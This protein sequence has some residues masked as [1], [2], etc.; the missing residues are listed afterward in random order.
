MDK[1]L[2]AVSNMPPEDAL[3]QLTAVL[4]RMLDDLDEEGRQRFVKNLIEQS[5]GDKVSSLVHL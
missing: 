1:F 4:D 2:E 5:Q 3:S